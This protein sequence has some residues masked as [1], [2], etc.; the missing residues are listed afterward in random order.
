[1][2]YGPA[3]PQ[4]DPE[5][6][7]AADDEEDGETPDDRP[8]TGRTTGF[9]DRDLRV[10]LEIDRA[11]PCLMDEV[12]DDVL[13]V[14][15][16]LESGQCFVDIVLR[17][18]EAADEVSTKHF[19]DQVCSYCPGKAFAEYGC[20]PRYLEVQ[21]GGFVMETYVENT[22]TVSSLVDDLRE[23]CDRVSLRSLVSTERSGYQEL[24]SVDLSELTL[25]QREAVYHAKKS[26]YYDPDSPVSLDDLADRVGVSSSALSQRLN[27]AEKNVLKQLDYDCPCVREREQEQLRSQRTRSAR[28]QV[29]EGD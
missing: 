20:L 5:V 25:K 15:V 26:G 17:D 16:R 27:R 23:M 2:D 18:D 7:S 9:E 14:D 8:S 21:D 10:I 11:G 1:M 29:A 28:H 24:C 4:R 19:S 22:E 6:P 3:P 12:A 13:D